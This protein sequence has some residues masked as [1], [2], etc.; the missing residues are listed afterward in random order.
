MDG[1]VGIILRLAG[2]RIYRKA[3][4]CGNK[5]MKRAPLCGDFVK[6]TILAFLILLCSCGCNESKTHVGDHL[7]PPGAKITEVLGDSW[8]VIEWKGYRYLWH[9]GTSPQ[10]VPVG[11]G[12]LD[13]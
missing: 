6:K 7:G 8:Y 13:R 10:I 5:Y 11:V 4:T 2:T 3:A 9:E 1:R 12:Q